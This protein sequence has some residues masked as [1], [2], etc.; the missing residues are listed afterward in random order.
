MKRRESVEVEPNSRMVK[1]R[2]L[3]R[4]YLTEDEERQY[5]I[6]KMITDLFDFEL[7]KK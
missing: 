5:M 4:K 3:T 2:G 6:Y 7:L 1:K